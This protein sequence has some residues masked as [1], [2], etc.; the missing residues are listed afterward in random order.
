VDEREDGVIRRKRVRVEPERAA[1][2]LTLR[3][4][5]TR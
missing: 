4:S 2:A 3:L 1:T 5:T